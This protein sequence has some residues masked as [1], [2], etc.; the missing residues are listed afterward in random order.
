M[1]YCLDVLI[2]VKLLSGHAMLIGWNESEVV[3]HEHLW[4]YTGMEGSLR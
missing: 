3:I 4:M 1:W 2:N